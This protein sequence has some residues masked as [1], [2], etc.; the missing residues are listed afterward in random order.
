MRE[1]I[2]NCLFALAMVAAVTMVYSNHFSNSFQYDDTHTIINNENIRSLKNIPDF[3]KDGSTFSSLPLSQSY[4]PIVTTTLTIDYW[5][6]NGLDTFVY[7][8]DNFAFFLILGWL[9]FF[10]Y[11]KILKFHFTGNKSFYLALYATLFFMVHPVMAETVNYIISRSVIISTVF[12]V[13]AFVFYQYSAISRK[14]YLYL[15]PYCLSI[16]AKEPAIMFAPIFLC[17]L[18]L[19]KY[20]LSLTDVFS[21]SKRKTAGRFLK[22]GIVPMT[23]CIF[24][25]VFLMGMKP[26]GFVPGGNSVFQYIITQPLVFCYYLGSL[27]LPLGLNMETDWTTLKDIWNFEFFA[28]LIVIASIFTLAIWTSKVKKYRPISFGILWFFLALLPTSS[29]IPLADVKNDHRMFFPFIGLILAVL[30]SIYLLIERIKPNQ[31][32]KTILTLA[33]VLIL[34]MYSYGTFQRNKV[35]KTEETLWLDV[36]EKSPQNGKALVNCGMFEMKKGQYEKAEEYYKKALQVSPNY[37][38]LYVNYGRLK[39]LQGETSE[40]EIL[41]K[42]GTE[43]RP[44]I[45]QPWHFFALF[46][47]EQQRY[48]LAMKHLEKAVSLSEYIEGKHELMACYKLTE[49]WMKLKQ[50]SQSILTVNPESAIAKS[51]MQLAKANEVELASL[52]EESLKNPSAEK[53]L[54]LSRRFYLNQDYSKSLNAA[55]KATE[56]NPLL[57]N[58]YNNICACYIE[59]GNYDLAKV[60]CERALELNPDN[61]TSSN[62]LKNIDVALMGILAGDYENGGAEEIRKESYYLDVSYSSF[63]SQLYDQCISISK[64]GLL[65]FPDSY[66]LFNNLCIC[67]TAKGEYEL[68]EEACL[69]G[70]QIAPENEIINQNYEEVLQQ[71]Q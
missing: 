17:Y 54:E 7:H 25:Y 5:I 8:L 48:D 26:D 12:V 45:H 67:H 38:L 70:L 33:S 49:N 65:K 42:K 27:I 11:Q 16:L 20:E 62:N 69:R 23:L 43:L 2:Q 19:F 64:D 47:K 53:M 10:F 22:E 30:S 60:N 57:S 18:L 14:Y 28:S 6:A 4:R 66:G 44:D 40:A 15:I 71:K 56:L 3:F 9:L 37:V 36:V 55:I 21:Q 46:Y 61:V 31:T 1:R 68:A 58:G 29:I 50:L 41:L 39:L 51:Y 35:W 32:Q 59:L 63:S 24:L 13:M 52:E 34:G